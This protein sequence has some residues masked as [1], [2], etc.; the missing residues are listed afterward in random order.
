MVRTAKPVVSYARLPL[1][2]EPNQGQ[3]DARV[4]FLS[5]GPGYTL[6]LTGDEAVLEL[7]QPGLR[8]QDSGFGIQ[9]SVR[10]RLP[11]SLSL[12]PQLKDNGPLETDHGPRTRDNGRRSVLRLK[13]VNANQNAIVTGTSELPGKASYFIGN[14]PHKW[15]TNVPTYAKVKY[16]GVYPGVDLVFY[17]NQRQLEYDF[18]VAP[19]ADP[20]AIA[21]DVAAG[22][23][24]HS[25][26]E[27]GGVKPPLQI[28]ADGDLVIATEGGEVHLEKPLIYQQGSGGRRDIPGGYVLK[29]TREVAF[30]VGAYDRT[31]PLVIDPVLA[32]STYLGGSDRDSGSSVAVDASGNAYVTGQTQ[33]ANFPTTAGALQTALAGGTNVFV[34]KLNPSGSALAYSTYLGGSG[35][36][37]GEGIAVDSS[38]HA[39]TTGLTSSSNFPTTPGA[40]QTSLA[41]LPGYSNAFIT[42]LD[43]SGS[44]LVY[45]TYLGGSGGIFGDGGLSVALDSS[46]NAYVAGSTSSSDFPTTAGAFQTS[47]AGSENAF[48]TKLNPSGS[49]LVYSTYL[50]G[51]YED[52]GFGIAV[53]PSGSAYVT[54][55][56]SS[57]NFPT[58]PGT[59]QTSSAGLTD[60]FVTKLNPSG[61]AL[62]FS[63]YLGGKGYDYSY[64]I[65]LDSSGH[66]YVTGFTG[67]SNFPTTAG[68]FQA[69]LAG[70]GNT[71]VTKLNPGGSALV[72]STY[73][74]GTSYDWGRG[75]AVDP[76]GDAYM[77]GFTGSSNFPTTAGAFQASLAGIQN[78]FVTE[79][80][81]SGSAL[82]YSTYLG[83]SGGDSG[84]AIA[85]DPLGNPYVTG[86]AGSSNFPT[87]S[88]AF[89]TS[90][91]GSYNAFVAK[92]END[93]PAQVTNLQSTVKN[94]VSA[95]TISPF[96]GQLLLA[97]LNAALA[98]LGAGPAVAARAA[99]VPGEAAVKLAALD[100]SHT[101]AAIRDLNEFIF[102]VR[103]LVIFRALTKAEG[104]ILIDA[105]ES[106]ITALRD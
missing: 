52:A 30:K 101:V 31:K 38:G 63:T 99:L 43:P 12:L 61:S 103:L 65:A 96:V 41:A 33:S 3:T 66:A 50:G 23:P 68:A 45:S 73:I 32:Y 94:L 40:F 84:F 34:T 29:S 44:S 46:G 90:L 26:G 104:Q 16:Q 27:D 2:F 70:G 78:A 4:K 64:G 82:V 9:E 79:L 56:A 22:L 85:V 97:P 80:H 59:F 75:I 17:G 57:S 39:Y 81:T 15:R 48:V 55:A 58:S 20:S 86:I 60:A 72:Y 35:Y 98:D 42:K 6:F 54:G 83:G 49:A 8:R 92:F 93:P 37:G 105:A 69:S 5:H 7:Q 14:D 36:D 91:A 11:R 18:V 100:R 19:G 62:I 25:S 76:S 95:G 74:G 71:F 102:E 51:N 21:L 28:S 53:D 77:T 1:S 13:L 67:S 47:L 87:T 106:L 24:R 88:G 10:A 89:Q